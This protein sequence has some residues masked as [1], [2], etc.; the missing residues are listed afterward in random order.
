MYF[1]FSP[2]SDCLIVIFLT[3]V[4]NFMLAI[5][6]L[7]N[8]RQRSVNRIFSFLCGVVSVLA[9]SFVFLN[10]AEGNLERSFWFYSYVFALLLIP[11]AISQQIHQAMSRSTRSDRGTPIFGALEWTK[12]LAYSYGV[13]LFLLVLEGRLFHLNSESGL[14]VTVL[15]DRGGWLIVP[16][17]GLL[18]WGLFLILK[19]VIKSQDRAHRRRLFGVC[20]SST[21]LCGLIAIFFLSRSLIGRPLFAS[22]L[23]STLTISLAILAIPTTSTRLYQIKEWFRESLSYLLCT[24]VMCMT[25]VSLQII[26]RRIVKG[27]GITPVDF[28][29]SFVGSILTAFMLLPRRF[30]IEKFTDRLIYQERYLQGQKLE[31]LKKR[32]IPQC[33]DRT[34][35]LEILFSGLKDCG[36][37]TGALILKASK[38]P[39][40]RVVEGWGVPANARGLLL[41]EDHILIQQL[42]AEI[43]EDV[44]RDEMMDRIM[45]DSDRKLLKENISFLQSEI[46]FP[47]FRNPD[48]ALIG[49]ITL[50]NV[51]L[52]S[53]ALAGR[54]LFWLQELMGLA[55]IMLK[56]F[57]T[58]E[59]NND[60][61]RYTGHSVAEEVKRTREDFHQ[62]K[63]GER[64]WAAI[65]IVDIRHF[66]SL[67][68]RLEPRMIGK[69]LTKFGSIVSSVVRKYGGEVDKG[70]GDALMANFGVPILDDRS[71]PDKKAVLCAGEILA[72]IQDA[73][74]ENQ[75][76][77]GERVSIGIGIGSGEVIAG[78]V[79][80]GM[81][82]EYTVIGDAPCMAARLENIAQENQILLSPI[83][84][85]QIKDEGMDIL[86]WPPQKI[87]GF[88]EPITV[89]ELKVDVGSKGDNSS[90][91]DNWRIASND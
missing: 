13:V 3:S 40:Y 55:I 79:D 4:L 11:P 41:K 37:M 28:L 90:E 17:G 15:S 87:E 86:A 46:L 76:P 25:F 74:K 75:W 80:W 45:S 47:I 26:V 31:E 60:L 83:T 72:R 82:V 22:I 58:Q 34:G 49:F 38:K 30:Y 85:E 5:R 89:Y 65:L 57:I 27:E 56:E 81:R 63:E 68:R 1:G 66:T 32:K 50:G 14:A 69:I 59:Q 70:M 91:E 16:F 19:V 67:S 78:N 35:L 36:F 53:S 54:N 7:L 21:V 42:R 44:R 29:A 43:G 6:V 20:L 24:A 2:K 12:R 64:T 48:R 52:G 10:L 23:F 61:V 18:L 88:E 39:F 77:H 33:R 9:F 8:S 84:F 51:K 73:N 71:N 62:D